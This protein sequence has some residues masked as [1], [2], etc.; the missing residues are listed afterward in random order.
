MDFKELVDRQKTYFYS[1][2]TRPLSFRL[3]ALKRLKKAI[4]SNEAL[5][6]A[7]LKDDLNKHASESYMCETGIVLEEI[8]YHIKHLH[9]WIKN[10]RVRTPLTQFRS[11][12]FISPEPYGVALIM[13]PWNYPIQLCLS[14]LAGA[15]SAGN[16][17]VVKPSAYASSTSRAIYE[18][19]SKTFPAEYISVVEGGR[20]QN[21]ALLEERFDYIFFTGSV[22]VGK[23]VMRAAAEKLTPMTLEL[24]GKSPVIVD[25][26]ADIAI[27]ARRIAFGKIL[28]A[29]QTCVAPDYLF[30]HE[31]VKDIFIKEFS[32]AVSSFF[33]KGDMSEM[34]CIINDVHFGRITELM[35]SGRV[36]TGGGTDSTRRFIEP[37]LLGDVST[38]SA[39]MQ[40]E[41]FGPVLPILVYSAIE[42]C[43]DFIRSRPK[44]LALYLFTGSSRT[45]KLIL[46]SCSFGGGCINDT[47]IHLA[48][49]YMGFGGVGDSGMGSY[50]GRHSFDTFSHNRSIVKKSF[51]PDLNMRYHP[52]SDK[53][54]A[55]IRRFM[56]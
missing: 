4:I 26:T 29:G 37:T 54:D 39:V 7:A 15:V 30:I 40:E 19:L 16:C 6:N 43:I 33:P 3:D 50:H 12:S 56:K 17:A 53:K 35:Q 1:G 32:S 2:A 20:E 21:S 13:S 5:I 28:N 8:S 42:N 34:P 47:V 45:E 10:K 25:D 9:E 46:E 18:M 36:L 22:A 23:A 41:I 52:Y 51:W 49:P 48:T 14:P 27:A 31:K 11:K 55:V 38:D 24:G 44:P